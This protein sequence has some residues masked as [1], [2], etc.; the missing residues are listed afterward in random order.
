M[1]QLWRNALFAV[2][3]RHNG[4][5]KQGAL[6]VISREDDPHIADAL[7]LFRTVRARTEI[8]VRVGSLESFI[9]AAGTEPGLAD[10]FDR[11]RRRYLDLTLVQ[12]AIEP[13]P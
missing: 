7:P 11:F 3:V 1:N 10:W 2:A 5:F 13:L 9:E 4:D 8:R 12:G 6:L